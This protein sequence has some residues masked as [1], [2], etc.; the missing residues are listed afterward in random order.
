MAAFDT[1]S[2]HIFGLCRP[3]YEAP[4]ASSAEWIKLERCG[5]RFQRT[6]TK[7][8]SCLMGVGIDRIIADTMREMVISR[9][10]WSSWNL[11]TKD[12]IAIPLQKPRTTIADI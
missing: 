4:K 7:V 1:Q 2:G 10:L 8:S 5:H 11:G 12:M 3:R 9:Q 6:L